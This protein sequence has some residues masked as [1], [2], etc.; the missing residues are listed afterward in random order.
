MR[1][2]NWWWEARKPSLVCWRSLPRSPYCRR[3]STFGSSCQAHNR[4]PIVPRKRR[5]NACA[6]WV[7]AFCDSRQ[8][9][10]PA[11]QSRNCVTRRQ[12]RRHLSP[13]F[14]AAVSKCHVR[15][16]RRPR[17]L[18][19]FS[20]VA[21]IG[22]VRV[23]RSTRRRPRWKEALIRTNL[24][25]ISCLRVN[26]DSD[27]ARTLGGGTSQM[28]RNSDICVH[29]DALKPTPSNTQAYSIQYSESRVN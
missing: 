5:Q 22:P 18:H 23:N 2:S 14:G 28:L 3:N 21:S 11:R 26:A 12:R 15:N 9:P 4:E 25:G 13:Y 27:S 7:G 20:E 10:Q 8:L 1:I 19:V 24:I 6:N 29:N 17:R 16:Y